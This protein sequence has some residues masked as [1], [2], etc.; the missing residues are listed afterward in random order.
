MCYHLNQPLT[1]R[2]NSYTYNRSTNTILPSCLMLNLP[3]FLKMVTLFT[4]T[5]RKILK[6]QNHL[7]G[8]NK[9]LLSANNNVLYM[10]ANNCHVP[11]LTPYNC[12]S[13]I[14]T[15]SPPSFSVLYNQAHI[16]SDYK[17]FSRIASL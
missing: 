9:S 6:I 15:L 3:F 16:F 11:S 10:G 17:T 13:L 2:T 12:M 14:Y 7:V 4:E 5:G 8:Y 1:P